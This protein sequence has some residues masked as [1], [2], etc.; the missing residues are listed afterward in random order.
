MYDHFH[1]N[2]RRFRISS[3]CF[4]EGVAGEGIQHGAG[5]PFGALLLTWI[6]ALWVLMASRGLLTSF[7]EASLGDGGPPSFSPTPW[8]SYKPGVPSPP[9]QKSF[10]LFSYLDIMFPG[11]HLFL[12]ICPYFVGVWDTNFPRR[13]L[14]SSVLFSFG[15]ALALSDLLYGTGFYLVAF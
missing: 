7:S 11:F 4:S 13:L 5:W 6:P 9:P 14:R 15:F 2:Q 3:E 10:L 12:R 8:Q 1:S